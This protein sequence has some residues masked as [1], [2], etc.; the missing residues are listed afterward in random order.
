MKFFCLIAIV[1]CGLNLRAQTNAPDAWT[2]IDSDSAIFDRDGHKAT[3][4]GHVFVRD[5]QGMR[6][7][8]EWLVVDLPQAGGRVSH[9]VAETNVVID[10]VDEKGQTNHATGDFAVYDYAVQNSVTNETVTLTGN[11]QVTTQATN[12]MIAQGGDK[13]IFDRI[14]GKIQFKNPRGVLHQNLN[15][16]AGKTNSPAEIIPSPDKKNQ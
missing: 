6:L 10:S 9:T 8:C 7:H 2:R 3:Y 16:A 1:F 5:N 11:P 4:R 15:G 14:T 13:I 12:S